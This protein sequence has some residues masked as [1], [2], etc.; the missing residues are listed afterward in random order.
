MPPIDDLPPE[1]L[2]AFARLLWE[3]VELFRKQ[4]QE[5]RTARKKDRAEIR[6]LVAMIE[7]LTRQLDELLRDRD[8][9]RAAEV[10]RLREEARAAAASATPPDAST[11]SSDGSSTDSAPST[12]AADTEGDS[13]SDKP[14]RNRDKHG[15]GKKPD[16]APRDEQRSRAA[17]C[18]Q[19][20]KT[21]LRDG[22]H[23]A[24]IEEW[25]YVRAHLRVRRTIPVQ[26][27]CEDCGEAIPAPPPPPMPFDRAACTFALMA[28]LCFAK[29]GLFLPLDRLR[30][31]FEAQGVRLPSATLT[32][33][34]QRGADLLHPVAA[35]VRLSLLADTHMRMDGTGLKVVFPR[36]KGTP[37][38]GELRAGDTD[39]EGYLL[40][41]L[42]EDGQ[43]LVFGNDEH[44]VFVYTPSR[45]GHHALDFLTVGTN[46][47]GEP[48]QWK[49][50]ITADALSA[51]DC[52]FAAGSGRT[53]GGCNAHGLR[54]FR[55]DKDKAP[56][57]ASAALGF[58]GR[59]FEAEAE[60]R[61][62]GLRGD[63]LLAYRQAH[64][65][66]AA[67]EFREWIDKNLDEL[68]PSH[69]VRKA[70]K[71]YDNHWEA[72]TLFLR[73]SNVPLDNNWSERAL[74]KVALLRNNSLYAGGVEGAVRL[75]TIFTLIGTCR[76]LGVDPFAYLEWALT[77]SVPHPSNRGLVPDDLTPAAYKAAHQKQAE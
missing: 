18:P 29:G 31:D 2:R 58:I 57:L 8:A 14:S 27:T 54:K 55:D 47:S 6:R 22:K 72:L 59:F 66:P 51:Y 43:I 49:G 42:P 65:G 9:E 3:Q 13:P 62:Q 34:W 50:T 36:A 32:R 41:R 28:W 5:E 17:V 75:C 74:R 20:G 35:S 73:D 30:R 68:L 19:C 44:A 1:G 24:P 60:A 64:A 71:Y 26:A 45:K 23:G 61:S 48:I 4:L 11:S 25:D 39:A 69:P 16:S 12:S 10:A 56:L 7:G 63:A 76:Q 21:H 40:P 53:E 15:R 33:W 70:M 46:A 38:K 52:L 37:V 67:A 77:R